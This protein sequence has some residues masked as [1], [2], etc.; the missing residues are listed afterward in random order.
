MAKLNTGIIEGPDVGGAPG[1]DAP[2]SRDGSFTNILR[3]FLE[4][5]F[6]E[7]AAK[8]EAERNRQFEAAQREADRAVS[9]KAFQALRDR[10]R[11]DQ[12][13]A[14]A[15]KDTGTETDKLLK[16]R[17][18]AVDAGLEPGSPTLADID[19][20]LATVSGQAGPSQEGVSL[21]EEPAT[22]AGR[23]AQAISG[24]A[25]GFGEF[26][27]N[28][29]GQKTGRRMSSGGML[30]N[31]DFPEE[32][33]AQVPDAITRADPG[34]G[35]PPISET[36]AMRNVFTTGG[37]P[38]PPGIKSEAMQRQAPAQTTIENFGLTTP[39]QQSQFS[40]IE[41]GIPGIRGFMA[42][43]EG[44]EVVT[45]AIKAI[46]STQGEHVVTVDDIIKILKAEF[47]VE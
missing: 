9:S 27:S 11:A 8:N 4:G 12:T 21:S 35:V 44:Q 1:T 32:A 36:T 20:K 10:L 18:A 40:N 30:G 42:T 37:V 47:G 13:T 38:T 17:K 5:A 41:K 7:V 22:G 43:P 14:L 3:G 33:A 29:P 19:A 26:V 16:Q 34:L 39:Q 15:K 46:G 45:A 28:L 23:A 31:L 2:P 25:T 24:V 6:P